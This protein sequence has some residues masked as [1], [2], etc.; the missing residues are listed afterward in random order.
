M[1]HARSQSLL[2]STPSIEAWAVAECRG[3]AGVIRGKFDRSTGVT[4]ELRDAGCGMMLKK[5]KYGS[6]LLARPGDEAGDHL[7]QLFASTVGTGRSPAFMLLQRQG[8]EGFLAALQ[9][10]VVIHGHGGFLKNSLG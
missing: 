3:F 9:T 4:A 5:R 7:L 10:F 2:L 1:A 8:Q 6:A